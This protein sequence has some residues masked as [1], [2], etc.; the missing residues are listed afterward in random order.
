[1][2]RKKPR[3]LT[4]SAE[5]EYVEA[6]FRLQEKEKPVRASSLA[7]Y[8][9]VSPSS[10]SEMLKR[11]ME[12]GL[13]E[14]IGDQGYTLSQEGKGL[15][16]RM[17]RAHR[18]SER[19]LTDILGISWDKVHEEACQ[20]EHSLSLETGEALEELLQRPGTCPHG[21]PIPDRDGFLHEDIAHPLTEMEP[22]EMGVIL[23]VSEEEPG[24]LKY[25]ATL[26]LLPETPVSIE[27]VAPLGGPILVQVGS[28]KYA[29]GRE[30]ASKILVKERR[31]KR[32]RKGWD[33]ERL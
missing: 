28:S 17:I 15:A 30:V 22:G 7:V 11:L 16:L 9:G 26:G 19:F 1:M 18:L 12:K 25:L 20:L 21:Q 8:L 29:L 27:E 23:K 2:F 33:G 14:R 3:H 24:L 13:V 32:R 5:E 10:A 31:R 4:S 6:L